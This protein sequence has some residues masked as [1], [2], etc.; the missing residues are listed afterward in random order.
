MDPGRF[1]GGR[2]LLSAQEHIGTHDRCRDGS[3]G[4]VLYNGFRYYDPEIGRYISADPIGQYGILA[5]NGVASS[6]MVPLPGQAPL[7]PLQIFGA[8]PNSYGYASNNPT[9]LIDPTG[10]IFFTAG[11][12]AAGA[13]ISGLAN[14]GYQYGRGCGFDEDQFYN[15][16]AGGALAG[17]L[18]GWWLIRQASAALRWRDRG[19]SCLLYTSPSPRD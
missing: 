17:G 9:N 19:R 14:L 10:E 11:F 12:A 3:Y 1:V 15:A 4:R 13:A 2:A 8:G 7:D 6:R 18:L 5:T 16:V